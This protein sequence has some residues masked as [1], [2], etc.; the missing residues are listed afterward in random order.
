[1]KGVL[2]LVLS[3]AALAAASRSALQEQAV[4]LALAD[5]HSRGH[6]HWLFK[7]KS[8][9]GVVES[10]SAAMQWVQA[11]GFSGTAGVTT[12][13]RGEGPGAGARQELP[14]HRAG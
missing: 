11:T 10:V 13:R 5:F 9:E 4:E 7:E 6:I 8:V 14:G 12:R 3:L 1:M 2:A